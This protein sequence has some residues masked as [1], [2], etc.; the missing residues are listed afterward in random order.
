[1][2]LVQDLLFLAGVD[3]VQP[4]AHF[5]NGDGLHRWAHAY[6]DSAQGSSKQTKRY[7][8]IYDFTILGLGCNVPLGHNLGCGFNGNLIDHYFGISRY[9]TNLQKILN[10]IYR[11][12][13][14]SEQKSI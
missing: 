1:M 2:D 9:Q 11:N 5:R 10:S 14:V 4:R 7:P 3:R 6:R 12:K 13:F 8:P